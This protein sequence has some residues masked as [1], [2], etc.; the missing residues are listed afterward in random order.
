MEQLIECWARLEEKA[1]QKIKIHEEVDQNEVV[2]EAGQEEEA[3]AN[4]DADAV[5]QPG[6]VGEENRP[7]N[8][9]GPERHAEGEEQENDVIIIREEGEEN[10]G[11]QDE[12]NHEQFQDEHLEQ[13]DIGY[14]L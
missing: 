14:V 6:P 4:G 8:E 9:E 11:F 5:R 12:H 7:E 2:A 10:A 13:E 1:E 3:V